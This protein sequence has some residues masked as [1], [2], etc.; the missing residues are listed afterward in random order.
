MPQTI[1]EAA[2][3]AECAC[4]GEGVTIIVAG[5]IAAARERLADLI[6]VAR[7]SRTAIP[8]PAYSAAV[9][10]GMVKTFAFEESQP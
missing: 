7:G 10:R 8:D 4:A 9:A 6:G 3:V 1:D 5:D 2:A